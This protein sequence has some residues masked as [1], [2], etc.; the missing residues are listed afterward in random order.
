MSIARRNWPTRLCVV[1]L[2]D[3]SVPA[4]LAAYTVTNDWGSG[5]QADVRLS[6]TGPTAVPF[7]TLSFTLPAAVSS[8]WDAKITARSGNQ[9][10]VTNPGWNATVPAG[11]SVSFGFVAAPGKVA[12]ASGFVFNG[13]ALGGTTSPPPV[14]PPPVSPPPTSPPP[15]T[16]GSAVSFR[17]TSDWGSGMGGELTIRNT[18]S[19]AIT[20]WSLAFT[21]PGSIDS[22]W[23]ASVA[24]RVGNRYVIA[25]ADWSKTIPAG[26]VVTVGFNASPGGI[27]ATDFL[28]TPTGGGTTSP[29]PVSPPPA[30]NRAPVANAD[31]T[32]AVTGQPV[33][34]SVLLND[35]DADGDALRVTAVGRPANGTAAANADGTV[36]YTPNAGF[37]GT[38]S[39][40]YTVSDGKGGSATGTVT[41][42]VSAPPAP[43]PASSWPAQV[44]APY[45]DSTLY[46]LYDFVSAARTT[47]S[48]YFTLAFIT[49]DPASRPAWGGY[50]EYAVT[51]TEFDLNMRT[52]INT[53][54]SLGGDV[55]VSFGGAAGRE[56]A[57]T[58]TDV[59][60]LAAAYRSVIQAYGLTHI[61]F[62]IEGAAAAHKASIDRRWEAV[63]IL[64]REAAAAGKELNVRLTLPVLPTG[65]TPDGVYVVTSA[66]ARG[67]RV[68]NVNVMAM[69]YG[70][71]AAPNP[72]GKMGDY[73]IQAATSLFNQLT[74]IY[75]TT[76]TEA[77]R[78]AMVGV[79][80]MIGMND[81]QT[82]IFDQQEARELVAWADARGVGYLG[83]WSLNRDRQNAAGRINYVDL[84]SSS[85]VQTPFEFT[86]IFAPFTG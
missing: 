12:A 44:F 64:Q 43:A 82:E 31:A 5:F 59:N 76:T 47:G 30:T 24:G 51:G 14:S 56:L 42:G 77:Q 52:K 29:P 3:R 54:R 38:D 25:P 16:S 80:P 10:T 50:A 34:V 72:G 20:N 71:S 17:S 61:D 63:A 11:G 49:A 73:A 35:S 69:D 27:A 8:I 39:F 28:F 46:P 83:F 75:G 67:V 40:T 57:E 58:I 2:E 85:V 37:T 70:D 32:S 62:D 68:D 86:G 13:V 84:F 23:N 74:A 22:I 55:A 9:Y 41:V 65:L 26:G 48:K 4:V 6:N 7:N 45:V 81:V 36:T 1:P 33:V 79:T 78:W 18:G 60:Q 21:L 53:L 66:K 15:A 19:T